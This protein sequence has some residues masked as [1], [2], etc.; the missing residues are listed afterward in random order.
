M[1]E[2][3]Y[4]QVGNRTAYTQTITD[5]VVTTYTYDAAN[6]L[7][8]VNGQTYTWDNNGNLLSDGS[9]NYTYDAANRLTG[10]TAT[11]LTWSAAYNGD[12][13]R[14]KQTIN[15]VKT[16][17]LLDLAA[18]LV[19]VLAEKQATSN[20]TYYLYGLGDS[21]LAS[22][23]GDGILSE[24]EGGVEGW[25]Y[26]SGRD[27]LNSVR[28]EMDAAGNVIAAR[29]FDPYGVPLGEDGGSPFGYT[30]EMRDEATGL[31]FLRARMYQP[32]LGI[33]LSRDMWAGNILQP[34]SMNGW[35]YVKCNPI[36]LV[37][38]SGFRPANIN[39]V[40]DLREGVERLL[41]RGELGS[42]NYYQYSCNCGWI[43]WS[44][45]LS[46]LQGET[47]LAHTIFSRL[48]ARVDWSVYP[49][50]TGERG[51]RVTSFR[52][53]PGIIVPWVSDIAVVPESN[54]DNRSPLLFQ[55]AWGIFVEHSEDVERRD[56]GTHTFPKR[57]Y[58]PI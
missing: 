2:Y 21:P 45:A 17:Y 11:G 48:K 24:A 6:R 19:T 41:Q 52:G 4:D 31:V 23:D 7:T 58:H 22:Y 20:K 53:M 51:V 25:T 34:G 39:E 33:F 30:G 40:G 13:A 44:H 36:N 43:D 9:K 56:V 18:P 50:W 29:S 3:A 57:I 12:G 38:P 46:G 14:T 5:T 27:G 28:Q 26:L 32:G 10:I 37:D 49:D 55:I 15:G 8:S 1:F 54:L 42:E 35:N 16:K 47:S